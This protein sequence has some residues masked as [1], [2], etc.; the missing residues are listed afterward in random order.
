MIYALFKQSE[1]GRLLIM[2][3]NVRFSYNTCS[4]K[5]RRIV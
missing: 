1:P 4:Y 5:L 2:Y 3:D